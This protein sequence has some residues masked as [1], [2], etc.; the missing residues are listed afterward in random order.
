MPLRIA[1][2]NAENLMQR[3]DFSGWRNELRRDRSLKMLDVRDEKHF[4]ALEQAR[5]VAHTD[6]TL[7]LTALAVADCRADIICMQEVENLEALDAFEYGYL[8]KM[9]GQG[10]RHKYLVE[11]NDTRGIDVCVMMR[12]ETATGEKIE[13]V[14]MQ[15][16]AHLT[17]QDLGIHNK[18]LAETGNEPNERVFRR[19]CLEINVRIGGRALTIYSVHFKSMGGGKEGV[20]GRSWTA[21]VRQAEAKAV[22]KLI[23]QKFGKGKTANKRWLICGDMNDYRSRVVVSGN[24]YFGHEFTPDAETQAGFDPLFENDFSYNLV[25]RRDVMDQW[26]LYHSRGPEE[27]HLCQLDYILASPSLAD[28]NPKAIPDIIRNG[29]P[30]RTPFPKGQEVTRYPRTGWDRPKASDHCPVVV[31]LTI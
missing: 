26:T 25:E 2:F 15:S 10:Y 20:D 1:T 14:S 8:F 31:E 24:R 4:Q 27:Q 9:A 11:G 30:F 5:V 22:R 3:F 17:Y 18:A 19:D 7:Q 29:Q 6:D 12:D 23:E 21:P 13:F 28:K 16:H